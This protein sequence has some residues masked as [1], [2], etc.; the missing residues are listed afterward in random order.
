M[1]RE[2]KPATERRVEGAIRDI[3]ELD[4]L[5]EDVLLASRLEAGGVAGPME[6]V[7]L[8]AVAEEETA[9][10]GARFE[11]QHGVKV[12]GHPRML[13]RMLR[14]LLDNARQHGGGREVSVGVESSERGGARRASLRCRPRAGRRPAD[15]ERIFEPFYRS[16]A[17][18]KPTA[19][20]GSDSPSFARSPA[21]TA[22]MR[23]AERGRVEALSSRCGFTRR[24][25]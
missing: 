8:S 6:W 17:T 24:H 3:E 16:P 9:R 20:S 15:R 2:E 4:D 14:N 1:M 5:V 25:P 11:G 21:T 12:A 10:V 22:A 18:P 19:E 7:D 13:R 23:R